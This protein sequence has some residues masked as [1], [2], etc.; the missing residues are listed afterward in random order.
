MN[1]VKME[2][3][4]N[5]IRL[6]NGHSDFNELAR[7]ILNGSMTN[8]SDTMAA[9]SSSALSASRNN[10]KESPSLIQRTYNSPD[11]NRNKIIDMYQV[12]EDEEALIEYLGSEDHQLLMA[13]IADALESEYYAD[14]GNYEL[15]Q[16]VHNGQSESTDWLQEE[17]EGNEE[18]FIICPICR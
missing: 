9:G 18:R 6:R 8:G 12:D 1:K 10:L 7:E 5:V 13:H 14:Y 3:E 16:S 17:A 15:S 11:S 4:K 2:R